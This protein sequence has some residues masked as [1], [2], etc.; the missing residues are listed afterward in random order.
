MSPTLGTPRGAQLFLQRGFQPPPRVPGRRRGQ[1]VQARQGR[2]RAEWVRRITV[3]MEE[4][5]ELVRLARNASKTA[6]VVNVAAIAG[7]R[8]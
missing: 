1:Q 3:T 4:R 7:N 6:R 2:R 8:P 5:L